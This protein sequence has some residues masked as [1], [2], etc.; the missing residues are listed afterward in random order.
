[1][2]A[3]ATRT[4]TVTTSATNIRD[5]TALPVTRSILRYDS[6]G[7]DI[8]IDPDSSFTYGTGTKV[9]ADVDYVLLDQALNFYAKSS[10][11]SVSLRVTDYEA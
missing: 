9:D 10:T 3:R 2:R 8:E 4:V 1:M 11:G 6:G 5:T 7:G